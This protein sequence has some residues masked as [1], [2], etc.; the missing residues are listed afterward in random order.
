MAG[1][2]PEKY[3]V[4]TVQLGFGAIQLATGVPSDTVAASYTFQDD[5]TLIGTQILA[6]VNPADAHVNADGDADVLMELSRQ[7]Q[8]AQPG[9]ILFVA[10]NTVWTAAIV[11]GGATRK[12]ESV[13]F[14]VG[15]GVEIDEG[16]A[17]N[18]LAYGNWIGAGGTLAM[19]GN[20]ILY[21][22]ER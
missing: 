19:Y 12:A 16:E 7:G 4:R 1:R 22:V 2:L 14:P 20:S 8:R 5:V 3:R 17:V 18:F 10:L 21:Y 6:E 15:Y 11:V 9:I 13:M